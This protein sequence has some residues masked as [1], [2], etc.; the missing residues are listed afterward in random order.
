MK[1]GF[2]GTGNMGSALA[3][4]AAK[5]SLSPEIFLADFDLAK[6]KALAE[7]LGA[8][9]GDNISLV[10][11]CDFVFLG[12]KPQV[13]PELLQEIASAVAER[14]GLTLVSMAAGISLEKLQKGLGYNIPLIRIMPNTPVLVEKGVIAYCGT[15]LTEETEKDFVSLLEKAG[16]LEKLEEGKSDAAR[17]L[18]GCGPAFV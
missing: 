11:E 16:L 10:R 5:S 13:L 7:K 12:V 9:V 14:K 18:H 1:I 4:A 6:A 3:S 17:A 2:I 15:N 8:S